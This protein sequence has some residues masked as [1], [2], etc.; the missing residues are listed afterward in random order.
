MEWA[1]RHETERSERKKSP[2][3]LSLCRL[4]PHYKRESILSRH[5]ALFTKQ[6]QYQ[7]NGTKR[8]IAHIH[9][10]NETNTKV[11]NRCDKTICSSIRKMRSEKNCCRRIEYSE[12]NVATCNLNSPLNP[13]RWR[14]NLM[15]TG[16]IWRCQTLKCSFSFPKKQLAP[17]R[18]FCILGR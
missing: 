9:N 12:L 2:W 17:F 11:I 15:K 5:V 16:I 8:T 1:K 14:C 10:F 18:W 13:L 6:R 7:I 4:Y 3:N